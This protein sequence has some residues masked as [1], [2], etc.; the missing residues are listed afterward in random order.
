MMMDL[1]SQLDTF[2]KFKWL[3]PILGGTRLEPKALALQVVFLIM[4]YLYKF[5]FFRLLKFVKDHWAH[6]SRDSEDHQSP[7][8]LSDAVH[9]QSHVMP[10][11]AVP[12]HPVM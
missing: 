10:V 4:I 1:D 11:G 2:S 5:F 3:W 12:L 7:L 9:E 6:V 8:H